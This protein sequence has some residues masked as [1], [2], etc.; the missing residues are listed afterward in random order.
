MKTYAIGSTV[1][2][3]LLFA[4]VIYS[5]QKG[6]HAIAAALCVITL[7]VEATVIAVTAAHGRALVGTWPF[8]LGGIGILMA[9]F[10]ALTVL[11]AQGFGW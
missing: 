5:L 2:S 11:P 3:L 9:C 8:L 6:G 1:W 10:L 7:L 4:L